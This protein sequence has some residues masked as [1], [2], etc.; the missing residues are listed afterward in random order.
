VKTIFTGIIQELGIVQNLQVQ[1]DAAKL[2]V[3]AKK[4]LADV[5]LGD[6]IAVNGVC[7]TVV[8]FSRHHFTVDMMPETLR[9]TNLG[10]LKPGDPV[11]LE[12]ALMLGGRLGGHLVSGHIDAVGKITAKY[13][14]SNAIIFRIA[15]PPAVMQYIIPKGSIA[16]DGI[17]L[18]VATLEQDT[19]TVSV[20]PHTAAQTTLGKRKV[21]DLVNLEND[22]IGKYVAR[23]LAG[24]R[25]AENTGEVTLEMLSNYG[26][27]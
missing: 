19:F 18:T 14:E 17:S 8:D 24:Q 27:L 5:N 11:N 7:L 2:S 4:I 16:V 15:A 6:S 26:F 10:Q 22:L 25:E 12:P 23:L 9:R 20:I 21:N 13:Q 3:R 1:Q